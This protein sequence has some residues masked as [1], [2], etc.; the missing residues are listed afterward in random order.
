VQCYNLY[1]LSETKGLSSIHASCRRDN[2]YSK[3]RLYLYLGLIQLRGWILYVALDEVEDWFVSPSSSSS[4][5]EPGNCWYEEFL[6]ANYEQC[7]GRTM[8]FSDHVVLYFA[9]IIPLALVEILHAGLPLLRN[10]NNHKLQYYWGLAPSRQKSGHGTSKYNHLFFRL[11]P[12]ILLVW[13]VNLYVVTFLGAFKTAAFF[14]TG[15]EVWLGF[16][17]S[18]VVQI[19]LCLLQTTRIFSKQKEYFFGS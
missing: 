15:P 8:D 6:H 13:L 18:L 19:P 14:H 1:L 2:V 17:I 10:T 16:L 12:V 9:Q 5:Q 7:Q 11:V 3:R 4:G